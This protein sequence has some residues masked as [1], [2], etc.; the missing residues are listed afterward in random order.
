MTTARAKDL[1][2]LK[3]ETLNR[4]LLQPFSEKKLVTTRR[5]V[6]AKASHSQHKLLT[7]PTVRL[8]GLKFCNRLCLL[9]AILSNVG[10]TVQNA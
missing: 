8:V 2:N 9:W 3:P 7:C 1:V 5:K 10:S 6:R 4:K